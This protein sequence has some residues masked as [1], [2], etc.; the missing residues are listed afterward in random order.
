MT[1]KAQPVGQEK[2][3]LVFLVQVHLVLH[4]LQAGATTADLEEDETVDLPEEESVGED[5]DS[6]GSESKKPHKLSQADL[7]DLVQNLNLSNCQAELLTETQKLAFV[8]SR[9]QIR[10]SSQ[11]ARA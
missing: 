4:N 3:L 1:L 10:F 11:A 6:L 7:T 2:L 8:G 9:N 5:P